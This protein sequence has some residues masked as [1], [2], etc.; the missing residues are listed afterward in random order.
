MTSVHIVVMVSDLGD[1]QMMDVR[2]VGTQR[3]RAGLAA[4]EI[5][6]TGAIACQSRRTNAR[7]LSSSTVPSNRNVRPSLTLHAERLAF[8]RSNPGR[9]RRHIYRKNTGTD[10]R[11]Y[12]ASKPVAAVRTHQLHSRQALQQPGVDSISPK[13]TC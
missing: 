10:A 7:M 13:R 6:S 3:S 1:R 8:G 5:G 12:F 2:H 4:M 9:L 11:P